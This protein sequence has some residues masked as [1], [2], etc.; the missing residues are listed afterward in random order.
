M[1]LRFKAFFY[2]LFYHFVLDLCNFFRSSCPEVFLRKGV[3]KIC[4]K[5]TEE[6]LCRSVISTKLQSNMVKQYGK[7]RVISHELRVM[8]WKLKSTSWNSKVRVQIHELRVQIHELR[9][10]IHEL[11]VQIHELR[12]QIRELRVQIHEFNND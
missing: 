12:V 1:L 6:H 5:F 2:V 4:S 7:T 3:L 8:S 9:V 10:Q 11:R